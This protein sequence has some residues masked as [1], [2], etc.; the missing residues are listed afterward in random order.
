MC[1]IAVVHR[2][3]AVGEAARPDAAVDVNGVEARISVTVGWAW[4]K[5]EP[6]LGKLQTLASEPGQTEL[7]Q[8]LLGR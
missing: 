2:A 4:V 3:A 1:A 5:L 7:K 6:D 8:F